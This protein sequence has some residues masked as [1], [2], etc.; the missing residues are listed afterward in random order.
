MFRGNKVIHYKDRSLVY[1]FPVAAYLMAG[2]L[3]HSVEQFGNVF[4]GTI[5]VTSHSINRLQTLIF[6]QAIFISPV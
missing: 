6:S 2:I 5:V 1:I 4:Y 3:L